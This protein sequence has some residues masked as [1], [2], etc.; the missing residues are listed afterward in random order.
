LRH[1]C[2]LCYQLRYRILKSSRA[3]AIDK[4]SLDENS[5][6]S[7][8]KDYIRYHN[9]HR[10]HQG[11]GNITIDEYKE[12]LLNTEKHIPLVH[13]LDHYRFMDLKSQSFADGLCNHYFLA[14]PDDIDIAV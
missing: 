5:L 12:Q 13:T 2:R 8:T 14:T 6:Y 3:T 1:L 7:I 11:I 10:P 4:D 9:R